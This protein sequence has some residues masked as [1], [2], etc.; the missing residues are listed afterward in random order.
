[1]ANNNFNWMKNVSPTKI[2]YLKN[3]VTG[4]TILDIGC[5]L[6]KYS[7]YLQDNG[8]KVISIDVDKHFESPNADFCFASG[9]AIPFKDKT[10]DTVILF[11]VLE[12]IE[13]DEKV[14]SEL[15]R[16]T[17]HRII[18]SVPNEDDH[19]LQK[20]NLTYKHHIDKSHF[21]EYTQE[22][23]KIILNQFDFTVTKI[24]PEGQISSLIIEDFIKNS[25]LKT[26]IMLPLKV[27]RQMGFIEN[28]KL[29]A[30]I[31]WVAQTK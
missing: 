30:D 18:G 19:I 1:M 11:D 21:R 8:Y 14:L 16:I 20:Y 13:N 22:K 7:R 4:N 27:L 6:G 31:F 12:H 24:K 29:Y 5:G 3:Y 15:Q 28:E 17:K 25:I 10:F 9:D 2:K 23:I 26:C